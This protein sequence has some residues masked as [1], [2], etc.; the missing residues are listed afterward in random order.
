[1]GR[2]VDDLLD[3][4]CIREGRL[5]LHLAPCDLAAVVDEAVRDQALLHP[6]RAIQWVAEARPVPVVADAGRIEQVVANYVGNALKF[7]REEQPVEVRLRKQDG[8]ARVAV[9]DEGIGL[10][11]AEQAQVWE[12]FHQAG[13]TPVQSGSRVGLGIGLYISRTIV[14][15]HGGQV[16]VLSQEGHGSIFWFTLPLAD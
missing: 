7:S 8:R 4:A 14:E 16:G 2:L 15:R 6:G 5:A 3:E 10:A 13:D 9:R 12:R 1:M 11:V